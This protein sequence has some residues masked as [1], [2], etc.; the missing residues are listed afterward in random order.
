M[1]KFTT[2]VTQ[3]STLL[4]DNHNS[5]VFS[6]HLKIDSDIDVVTSG[7]KSYDKNC[8][9]KCML[10]LLLYLACVPVFVVL[11]YVAA[12]MYAIVKLD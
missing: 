12:C 5:N 2:Y 7:G 9:W 8:T 3:K 10:T 4:F 6:R 11:S 1:K